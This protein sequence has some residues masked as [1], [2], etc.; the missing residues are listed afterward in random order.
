[1]G[2]RAVYVFKDDLENF[3][4]DIRQYCV[5]SHWDNY[6]KGAAYCLVNTLY[7]TWDF[8][9]YEADEFAASFIA[10]NKTNSGDYRLTHSPEDHDDLEYVYEIFQAKNGQMIVRAYEVD[11]WQDDKKR[12]EIFYGRMKDFVGKYGDDETKEKWDKKDNS[13]NK[14]LDT[15]ND[16]EYKEYVRLKNKFETV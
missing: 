12:T 7:N 2:T 8:P 10:A 14:L 16:P 13:P 3:P 11:F 1:M 4:E 9:R 6:P 15:S 5:Y